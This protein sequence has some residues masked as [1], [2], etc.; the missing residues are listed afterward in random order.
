LSPGAEIPARTPG[1]AGLAVARAGTTVE[2]AGPLAPKL[3]LPVHG[4]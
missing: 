4:D 3:P 1:A 2:V